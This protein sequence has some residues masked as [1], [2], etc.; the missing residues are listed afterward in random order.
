[1]TGTWLITGTSSGFGR[2]LTEFTTAAQMKRIQSA[3]APIMN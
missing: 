3:L 2:L 1:M